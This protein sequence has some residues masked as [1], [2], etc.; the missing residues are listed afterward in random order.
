MRTRSAN[1]RDPFLMLN[2][3]R[4]STRAQDFDLHGHLIDTTEAI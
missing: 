4:K 3:D 2:D 1:K